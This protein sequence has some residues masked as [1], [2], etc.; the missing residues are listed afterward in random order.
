MCKN[1][2]SY[3]DVSESLRGYGGK[4]LPKE[5]DFA[6]NIFEGAE[7]FKAIKSDNAKWPITIRKDI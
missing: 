3:M 2:Q 4:C 6:I 7:L 5:I 1:G